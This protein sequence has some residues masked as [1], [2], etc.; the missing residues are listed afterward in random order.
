LDSRRKWYIDFTKK[1]TKRGKKFKRSRKNVHVLA[2]FIISSIP[3]KK[4]ATS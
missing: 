4:I 2:C 3:G 1:H